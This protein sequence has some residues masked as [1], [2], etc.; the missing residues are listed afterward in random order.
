MTGRRTKAAGLQPWAY[1][2]YLTYLPKPRKLLATG[3]R[4]SQGGLA[5]E[6]RL[7]EELM[8]PTEFFFFFSSIHPLYFLYTTSLYDGRLFF[9]LL[10]H[11]ERKVFLSFLFSF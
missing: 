7:E 11:E 8:D 1:S 2:T 5:G 3:E 9:K 4:G 6:R 10:S